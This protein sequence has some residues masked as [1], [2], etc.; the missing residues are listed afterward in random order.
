MLQTVRAFDGN[1]IHDTPGD[2]NDVDF[3]LE[4]PQDGDARAVGRNVPVIPPCQISVEPGEFSSAAL[5]GMDC[6]KYQG[7]AITR[8]L[9]DGTRIARPGAGKAGNPRLHY[10][11][12][13]ASGG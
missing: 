5:Q 9:G 7:A 4:F 10:L 2:C 6:G 1:G 11:L 8:L 3:V 13:G 12:G